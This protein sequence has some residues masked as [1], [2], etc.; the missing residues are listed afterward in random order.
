LAQDITELL[1]E[2]FEGFRGQAAIDKLLKEKRGYIP[3]AFHREDLGDIALIWGDETAGLAHIIKR[4]TEQR[5]EI[6]SFLSDLGEVVE[7]GKMRKNLDTGN[8]ETLHNR[9]MCVIAPERIGNNLAFVLTAYK[10][11]KKA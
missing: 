1:G 10:T 11:R 7:N 2:K 6:N 8:F 3:A 4:R 9:K 5:I